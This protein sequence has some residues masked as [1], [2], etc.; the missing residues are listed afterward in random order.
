MLKDDYRPDFSNVKP[1]KQ[2][3]KLLKDLDAQ[4]MREHSEGRG[5]ENIRSTPR[6]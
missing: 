2:L 1:I 6:T 5:G 3:Q 4:W